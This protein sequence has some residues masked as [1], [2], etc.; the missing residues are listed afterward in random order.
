ME[1][2]EYLNS[3]LDNDFKSKLKNFYDQ[4]G[5]GI[6]VSYGSYALNCDF[7]PTFTLRSTDTEFEDFS[8]YD[9]LL[10]E[11]YIKADMEHIWEKY[12]D[13]LYETN[14]AYEPF[15]GI[16]LKQITDF[17]QVDS[18]YFEKNISGHF[19]YQIMPMMSHFT[20]FVA[21]VGDDCWVVYGPKAKDEEGPGAFYHESLHKV[22]NPIVYAN[23]QLNERLK[24]LL[25]LAQEKLNGDYDDLTDMICESFVRTID[26]FLVNKY[27]DDS[28]ADI[29]YERVEDEYKL[30]HILCLYLLET[31][32]EYVKSGKTLSEYYPMLISGID[33]DKENDRWHNYWSNRENN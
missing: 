1:I 28:Q 26:R 16:A 11:F 8:G 20:G 24:D 2:R 21:S 31:L 3:T 29:L 19:Y 32:P 13:T 33:I 12:K 5:G 30:G 10:Q 18:D 23:L 9:I 15:A 27:Y 4:H 25:P 6:F 22:V 14:N 17:C 7:P